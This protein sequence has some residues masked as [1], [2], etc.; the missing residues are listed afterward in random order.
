MEMQ[1]WVAEHLENRYDLIKFD[2]AEGGIT[3]YY[4]EQ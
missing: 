1:D 3:L 2:V 4:W